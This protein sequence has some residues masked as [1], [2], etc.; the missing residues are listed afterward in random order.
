TV[1]LVQVNYHFRISVR[2]K[3]V[4]LALQLAPQLSEVVN[5][6]VVGDPDA[7]VLIAHR[8][9]AVSR[10]IDNR[11]TAATQ[12]NI[13]TIG[14]SS[15][16]QAGVVRSAMRLDGRHTPQSFLVP[17]IG[18]PAYPAH[19]S[20]ALPGVSAQLV[21][22]G[23]DVKKLHALQ[24]TVNQSGHTIQKSKA[25]EILVQEEH[26]RRTGNAEKLLPEPAATL[27]L[28]PSKR[29]FQCIRASVAEQPNPRFPVGILV[30]LLDVMGKRFDIVMK[31]RIL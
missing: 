1:L 22:L 8:H 13:R 21:N 7:A 9:V 3:A 18:Q 19:T 5:L 17:A 23:F 15:F 27:R 6:A 29:W 28:V 25:E 16:P 31:K 24:A 4:A 12:T 30:M 26:D 2:G 14:K 11:E 20:S 10:K